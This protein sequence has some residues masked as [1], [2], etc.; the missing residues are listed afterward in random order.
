MESPLSLLMTAL[1][2]EQHKALL[3]HKYNHAGG[4]D[5]GYD[6]PPLPHR[7]VLASNMDPK[8]SC[9]VPLTD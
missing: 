8:I 5:D 1:E 3:C 2:H 6:F 7:Q 4:F 9:E